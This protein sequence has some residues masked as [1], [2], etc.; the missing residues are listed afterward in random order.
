MG[1]YETREDLGVVVVALEG[2]GGWKWG[3][4]TA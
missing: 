4:A 1:L 3:R 2:C